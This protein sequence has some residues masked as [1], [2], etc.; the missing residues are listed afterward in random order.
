MAIQVITVSL[1]GML[2]TIGAIVDYNEEV[3]V[4]RGY[5]DWPIRLSVRKITGRIEVLN[6]HP[7]VFSTD[8][9]PSFRIHNVTFEYEI[10]SNN[11]CVT[12]DIVTTAE[13]QPAV[14]ICFHDGKILQIRTE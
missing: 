2:V 10:W 5:L 11:P 3:C 7:K 8:P 14:S 13:R 9:N 1:V 6:D 4:W 12:T